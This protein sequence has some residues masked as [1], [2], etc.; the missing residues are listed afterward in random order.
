MAR[1]GYHYCGFRSLAADQRSFA[2]DST[3]QLGF[4]WCGDES[5]FTATERADSL[6]LVTCPKCSAAIG[7]HKLKR[8][9]GRVTLERI[10][11]PRSAYIKSAY[12]LAIDGTLRGYVEIEN[13][14]G[15]GW[16]LRALP[17]TDKDYSRDVIG[18][19][20]SR[21]DAKRWL[22]GGHSE[23]D[24]VTAWPV[25]YHSKE[26][27]AIA[28][29]KAM[30]Q[31]LLPTPEEQEA[32]AKEEQARRIAEE[33]E[34]EANRIEREK[35]RQALAKERSERVATAWLALADL[36]ARPD[37]SNIERAGIEAIKRLIPAMDGS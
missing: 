22:D 18:K 35:E 10:E 33:Q 12:A 8:L 31:G 29:L 17:M 4:T 13:G 5:L 6:R 26:A 30:T 11:K 19:E 34:R 15:K 2:G 27:M 32:R 9:G 14:W 37:L 28:G 24:R 23:P 21:W 3:H 16:S 1:R 25:H 36:D 20:P 7:K